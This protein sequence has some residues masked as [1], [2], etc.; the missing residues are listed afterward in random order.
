MSGARVALILAGRYKVSDCESFSQEGPGLYEFEFP[1]IANK[2][3]QLLGQVLVECPRLGHDNWI[4]SPI[5]YFY[6][7]WKYLSLS[8]L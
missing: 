6:R 4:Y 7:L 1:L 2:T 5:L 3:M 8:I